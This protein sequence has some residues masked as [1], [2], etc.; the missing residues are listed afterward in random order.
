VT[1]RLAEPADREGIKVSH[2]F[3]LGKTPAQI[4]EEHGTRPS[5]PEAVPSRKVDGGGEA[6]ARQ[7]ELGPQVTTLCKFDPARP[8]L[9]CHVP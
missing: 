3:A 9:G 1:I 7:S 6:P 5:S 2:L 8:E 4:A